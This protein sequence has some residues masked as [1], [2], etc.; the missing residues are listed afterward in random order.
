VAQDNLDGRAQ[1]G[2]DGAAALAPQST[3]IEEHGAQ[4]G[5]LGAD[6]VDRLRDPIPPNEG[7]KPFALGNHGATA[8]TKRSTSDSSL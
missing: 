4:A 2:G 1:A 6:N 3:R 7:Q 5:L 8:R